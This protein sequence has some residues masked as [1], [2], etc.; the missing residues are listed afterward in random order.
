MATTLNSVKLENVSIPN[1]SVFKY[2]NVRKAQ[3]EFKG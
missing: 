3:R 1:I 2:D